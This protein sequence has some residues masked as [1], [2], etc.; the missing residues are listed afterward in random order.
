[1][2]TITLVTQKGGA[3]KTTLVTNLAVAAQEDGENVLVLDLDPQKSSV[4]WASERK[5]DAPH[6]EPFPVD[7]LNQL[8]V[9]IQGLKNQFTLV[10]LD[11]AGA[12][13]TATHKAMEAADLCLVPLRPTRLDVSA[14]PPTVQAI[15]RGG[16]EFAFILNQCPPQPNN[17][18][19]FEM[20]NGLEAIGKLALPM[21]MTRADYQDA[22]AAGQGVLEFAPSGK[23]AEEIRALWEWIGDRLER[24]KR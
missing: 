10:I 13:N 4:A 16:S 19:A 6:V 15:M 7:R 12:D 14:V 1:M 21:I 17:P 20:K 22:Y 23:A 8:P 3:G 24:M 18:R 2:Q 9:M 11:T 5:A